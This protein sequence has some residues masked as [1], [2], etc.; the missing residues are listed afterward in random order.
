M[1]NFIVIELLL[2]LVGGIG[3]LV[4]REFIISKD[5]MLRKIMIAYFSVEVYTYLGMA[6]YLF[7]TRYKKIE[8]DIDVVR[9]I[10]IVPKVLIKLW[11]LSWLIQ[12]RRQS[13]N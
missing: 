7:L 2:S 12:G 9:Y 8:L 4:L 6:V 11:L 13:N 3:V 1:I 10:L 5:G